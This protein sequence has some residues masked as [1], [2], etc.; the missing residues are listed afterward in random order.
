MP[1]ACRRRTSAA[2]PGRSASPSANSAMNPPA[3]RQRDPRHAGADSLGAVG[4]RAPRKRSRERQPSDAHAATGD[5]P[6]DAIARM[7]GDVRDRRQQRP[8]RHGVAEGPR[9]RMLRRRLERRRERQ[10]FGA[11]G[12]SQRQHVQQHDL[13]GGQRA[14]LVEHHVRDARQRFQRVAARDDDLPPR[15]RAG[16]RGEGRR[17]RQRQRA[18]AGDDEH[19]EGHRQHARRVDLPPDGRRQ[20]GEREQRA[21][22]PAGDPIGDPRD[23]RPLVRR[24]LREALDRRQAR[25]LAG[26]ADP[27]H[28]R[29]VAH[30][31]A[32]KHGV[33]RRLRPRLRFAGQDRLLDVRRGRRPPRRRPGPFR[34]GARARA[35]RRRATPRRRSRRH[36]GPATPR[37]ARR[38]PGAPAP[39]ARPRRRRAGARRAR[40]SARRA[41]AR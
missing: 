14:G 29:A 26:R 11:R 15:Q 9:H 17:C 3:S 7:D 40:R 41:A 37:G 8:I 36:C 24:A 2:A 21:D 13:A 28:E 10:R 1:A 23:P 30:D 34:P 27:D 25:R 4:Q 39:R 5:G 19:G 22:E 20:R 12:G 38:S 18:G 6:F 31:A 35:P 16:R 32:R 33:S